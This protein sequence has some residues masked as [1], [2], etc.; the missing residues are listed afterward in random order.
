MKRIDACYI[1]FRR[2]GDI[3]ASFE[4]SQDMIVDVFTKQLPCPEFRMHRVS[5]TH[6][7]SGMF[8]GRKC[9]S[10][11]VSTIVSCGQLTSGFHIE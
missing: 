4:R 10:G 1:S 8:I 2:C 5:C 6:S 7:C 9:C 3:D 11:T